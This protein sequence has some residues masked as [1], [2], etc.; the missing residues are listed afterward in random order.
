MSQ[1]EYIFELWRHFRDSEIP[2]DAPA[3]Q[4]QDMQAAFYAGAIALLGLLADKQ[5]TDEE[6]VNKIEAVKQEL[7]AFSRQ[8]LQSRSST[9]SN[10]PV[11]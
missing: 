8:A 3:Y 9:C 7:L 1:P 10:L 4:F 2:E 11:V 6:A 5:C